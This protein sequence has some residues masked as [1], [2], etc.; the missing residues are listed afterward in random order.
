V[1]A[2]RNCVHNRGPMKRGR[3]I[4]NL[5]LHEII[6]ERGCSRPTAYKILRRERKSLTTQPHRV[7]K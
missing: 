5:R 7:A 4:T 2:N 6:R 3:P 1:T